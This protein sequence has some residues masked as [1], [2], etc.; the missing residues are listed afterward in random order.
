MP[1]FVSEGENGYLVPPGDVQA[2]AERMIHL[3]S[4][5]TKAKA[6]GQTGHAMAKEHSNERFVGAHE[7]LYKSIDVPV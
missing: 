6:M 1:E 5:P 2:M 4:A 3:L 7:Q